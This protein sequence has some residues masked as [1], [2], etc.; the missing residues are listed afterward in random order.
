MHKY[1]GWYN[2]SRSGREIQV[3]QS[4][5]NMTDKNLLKRV[6]FNNCIGFRGSSNYRSNELV[7]RCERGRTRSFEIDM[8]IG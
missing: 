5:K 2:S 7:D 6:V 1:F 8:L 3:P 4:Y